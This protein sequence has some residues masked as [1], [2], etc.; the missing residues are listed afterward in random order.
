MIR[1][2]PK[3]PD[4]DEL[5]A[6]AK[7]WGAV[8]AVSIL[9][10]GV[11]AARVTRPLDQFGEP[12]D[13]TDL[14]ATS[15]RHGL[16]PKADKAKLDGMDPASYGP[17]DMLAA[18]YD[19]GG[20][21]TDAFSMGNMAETGAAKVMTGDERTKLV[22][23]EAGAQVNPSATAIKTAYES[24]ADTNPFD[25]ADQAKL[26]G[27]EASANNYTLPAP[28]T[29]V[30]GGVKRNTGDAGQF[31]SGVSATGDLEFSTPYG[32]GGGDMEASVYDPNGRATDIF[33]TDNLVNGA[34]TVMMT[35]EERDKLTG[36]QAEANAYTLPVATT[37]VI[38]GVKRN[39]GTSGQFVNGVNSSGDLLYGTPD[40]G[41]GG[42]MLADTYDPG[43]FATDVFFMPNMIE[44]P[45]A[46]IM[47]GTERTK[48]AGI[49]AGA[50]DYSHPNHSGDVTSSG[51]GATTIANGVVVNSKLAGMPGGTLKGNA[52]GGTATP[53]DLEP[54]FVRS[55]L[56]VEDGAQVNPS[57]AAIKTAYESN[58]D[59]NAFDDAAQAKLAAIEA[60]ANAYT[61]PVATDTVI[62]GVKRN[63]GSLGQFVTG[64]NTSG[65]LER[66]TPPSL[67]VGMVAYIPAQ[68]PPTDWLV[69]DGSG[70]VVNSYSALTTAIYCGDGNNADASW[71]FRANNSDGTSRSTTGT[72][73]MLPDWRNRYPRGWQ[74]GGSLGLWSYYEDTVKEHS[75]SINIFTALSTTSGS[76]NYQ[77]TSGPRTFATTVIS[78]EGD[79]EG[80]PLTVL[81]LPVIYAGPS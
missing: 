12:A 6:P 37:T 61:L 66:S 10:G 31:V 72:Y 44:G 11:A 69:L 24:N 25:D 2:V 26:A 35:V 68:S 78:P 51:D 4:L 65:D 8:R 77:S 3:T 20:Q 76:Q 19:P 15:A 1:V 63:T 54:F 58:G 14:D 79:P 22:G 60:G 5:G 41:G 29:T 67:F 71:G 81:A 36:I 13:N 62:G 39:T 70:V 33:N 74:N 47:T 16:M 34:L 50:N 7:Q 9:I 21:A 43:G 64:I 40:G 56:N 32:G 59:T 48:L 57:A 18:T 23:I 45:E 46:K 28:T 80:R 38:G 17:G 55:L 27:I 53:Q 75:H 52:T 73:L 30:M 42:D 49:A